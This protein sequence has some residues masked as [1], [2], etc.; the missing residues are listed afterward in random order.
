MA[1]WLTSEDG[2][3]R[4]LRLD[5]EDADFIRKVSGDG[6]FL[7]LV[8]QG[9]YGEKAVV[10]RSP[11]L[12]VPQTTDAD[13][14]IS[15]GHLLTGEHVKGRYLHFINQ[16]HNDLCRSNLQWDWPDRNPR[17]EPIDWTLAE[18]QRQAFLADG[19]S[20]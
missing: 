8:K 9:H 7:T 3:K 6:Q 5:R 20:Q 1:V 12:H 14:G 19:G 16:D 15:A 2:E 17:Y 10:L 13:Q 4:V 11:A 18:K